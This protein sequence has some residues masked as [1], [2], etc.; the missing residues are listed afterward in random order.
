MD[1]FHSAPLSSSGR[2]IFLDDEVEIKFISNISIFQ[3]V[4]ESTKQEIYPSSTLLSLT[5]IRLIILAESSMKKYIGWCI[6]L[7]DIESII[8]GKSTFFSQSS[9]IAIL[10]KSHK[11]FGIKFHDKNRDEFCEIIRKTLAK[12]SWEQINKKKEEIKPIE[13]KFS[14]SNAGV[15]G[16]IRRQEKAL[17]SVDN[18]TKSALTDLDT[19][20][21]RAR[22]AIDV[23]QRYAAYMQDQKKEQENFETTTQAAEANEME[24]I[25]QSIG[26]ISP[27]TKLS[28]GRLFHEQ[29][30]RQIADILL[31]QNRIIRLGG[32]ITLTDL[33]CLLNK[34]RGTELISPD[35]L[36]CAAQLLEKLHLKMKLVTFASGVKVIQSLDLDEEEFSKRIEDLIINHTEYSLHGISSSDVAV[37]FNISITLAKERLIKAEQRGIV[38]RDESIQG[39][40]FFFNKFP[41]FLSK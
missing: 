32:M 7:K 21:D 2:P 6:N 38:C 14:V 39:L 28:A 5:N 17:T 30:A 12:K 31:S 29:L 24:T 22:E 25:M 15:S 4:T 23:V 20:I 10:L 13:Q 40:L 36:L 34:A 27:I 9:R 11:H 41:L 35:D 18:L 3:E 33:F 16:I 19:L 26:I 37:S 1:L 8:E